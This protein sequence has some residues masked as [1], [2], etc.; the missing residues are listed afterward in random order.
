LNREIWPACSMGIFVRFC[1]PAC[2]AAAKFY[3]WWTGEA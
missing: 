1:A 3:R 2:V